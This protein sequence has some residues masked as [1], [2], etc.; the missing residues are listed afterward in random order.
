VT[1]L[2]LHLVVHHEELIFNDLKNV[3]DKIYA[4]Q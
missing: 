3:S 4:N 1:D 2:T